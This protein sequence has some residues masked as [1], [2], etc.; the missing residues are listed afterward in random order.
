MADECSCQYVIARLLRSIR[1]GNP[2][3]MLRSSFVLDCLKR[4]MDA[5]GITPDE[6]ARS[7]LGETIFIGARKE[8]WGRT[9]AAHA[10]YGKVWVGPARS[11]TGYSKA[12]QGSARSG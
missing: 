7:L 5:N 2:A 3:H 8:D 6:V 4:A 9:A 11:G 10:R 12:R 1:A